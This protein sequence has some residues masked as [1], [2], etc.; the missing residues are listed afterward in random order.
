GRTVNKQEIALLQNFAEQAVIA[1][2]NSRLLVDLRESEVRHALVSDAVAEG[3]YEWNIE[4]NDLWVSQ[5]L[6]EIF[7]F[8][9][10]ELKAA[11]WNKLVHP[12][13]FHSY[14]SARGD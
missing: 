13:H 12:E 2:D 6:I 10:R 7:G 11:D 5:R 9:G 14:R 8:E 1:I 4:T 3:I